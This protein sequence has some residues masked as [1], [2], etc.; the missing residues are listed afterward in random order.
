M[1]ATSRRLLCIAVVAGSGGSLLAKTLEVP[2]DFQ[3]I[4]AAVDAASPGDVIEVKKGFYRETVTIQTSGI[5]LEGDGAVIDA[6][7]QGACIRVEANDVCIEDFRLKN[8]NQGVIYLGDGAEIVDCS[9]QSPGLEGLAVLGDDAVIREVTLRGVRD[10][11]IRVAAGSPTSVT[12][13]EKT[14]IEDLDGGRAIDVDGGRA[15]VRKNKLRNVGTAVRVVASHPTKRSVVADNEIVGTS[16]NAIDVDTAGAGIVIEDNR[17]EL[18]SVDGITARGDDVD[19]IGNEI[20]CEDDGIDGF[21]ARFLIADNR[22]EE[23]GQE[24]IEYSFEG[25]D[26]ETTI[27][28]NVIRGAAQDGILVGANQVIIARNDVRKCFGDGIDIQSG[29]G[30]VVSE[31]VCVKN[32]HEGIDNSGVATRIDRNVCVKN[33]NKVGPDI[34]GTGNGGVGSVASFVDNE[35]KTGSASTPQRLDY[36][37]GDVSP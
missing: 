12:K 10:V 23:V 35:F 34:A 37:D 24:G 29:A 3:T 32:A 19:I 1:R 33:A 7:Y 9:V 27:A 2:D 15:V 20:E 28:D 36:A 5:R 22:I 16:S 18:C 8:G 31:N 21:G 4:Q 11:A 13:I 30:C 14:S 6:E 25:P 17:V 26:S